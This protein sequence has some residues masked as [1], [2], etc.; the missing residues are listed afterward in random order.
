MGTTFGNQGE[1]RYY[2]VAASFLRMSI[3]TVAFL[4]IE[5]RLLI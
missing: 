5:R 1:V 3:E 2:L 4:F